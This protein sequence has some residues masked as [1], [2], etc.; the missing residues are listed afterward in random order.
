MY[1]FGA[2]N[3]VL[4]VDFVTFLDVTPLYAVWQARAIDL[5]CASGRRPHPR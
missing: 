1:G 4:Y 3:E 5:P 2:E